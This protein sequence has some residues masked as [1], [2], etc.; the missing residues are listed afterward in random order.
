MGLVAGSAFCFPE[1]RTLTHTHTRGKLSTAVLTPEFVSEQTVCRP[2]SS[3][4]QRRPSPSQFRE[5]KHVAEVRYTHTTVGVWVGV[6][7]CVCVIYCM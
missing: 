4:R 5:D 7:V 1:Q 2:L 3:R 6:C